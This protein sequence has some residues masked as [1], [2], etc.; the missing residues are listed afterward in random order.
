MKQAFITVDLGFGDAGKGIVVNALCKRYNADMIIRFCSGTQCGHNVTLSEGIW[1]EFHIFGSGTFQ[2]IPTLL[3]KDVVVNP[4][5]LESESIDLESKG[6]KNPM[7]LMYADQD[8]LLTTPY[9][10]ALNRLRE[11]SRDS[12]YGSCGLGFGETV[13]HSLAFPDQALR[14]MDALDHNFPAR[15][16]KIRQELYTQ[17]CWLQ[18]DL[19]NSAI[20]AEWDILQVNDA[21]QENIACS[22]DRIVSQIHILDVSEISAIV[23]NLDTVVFEGAQGILLD[24][25]YGLGA[26]NHATWATTTSKNAL[27]FLKEVQWDGET[28]VIGITRTYMTRHGAG[29][30][31]TEDPELDLADHHNQVNKYQGNF[32]NGWLDMVALKY[33]CEVD[34]NIDSL[35]ITHMDY[36]KLKKTWK[37]CTDYPVFG[38]PQAV[39]RTLEENMALTTS[40]YAEK[41]LYANYEANKIPA[42]I[43]DTLNLPVRIYSYGPTE[44]DQTVLPSD[45]DIHILSEFMA[46]PVPPVSDHPFSR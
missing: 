5:V 14:L 18:L 41:P 46:F 29:P 16:E 43:S 20:K 36:L 2:N 22:F 34:G 9:H 24:E 31:P 27:T 17:A 13:G 25:N 28:E 40:L 32:R 12:H 15:L 11:L 23:D 38:P 4:L 6:I 8:C 33:A 19:R 7:N 1:H 39:G 45:K 44:K 30:F 26:P 37:V 10:V 3:T 21:Y 35:A 42:L